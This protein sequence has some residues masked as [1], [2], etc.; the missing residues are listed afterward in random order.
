M[1]D[2]DEDS[3]I[4]MYCR[5]RAGTIGAGKGPNAAIVAADSTLIVVNIQ[6]LTY[7]PSPVTVPVGAAVVCVNHEIVAHDGVNP[8]KT[9]ESKLLEK[10]EQFPFTFSKPGTY[11]YICSIQPKMTGDVVVK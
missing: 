7:N 6:R 1:E 3:R 2:D 8:D 5:L 11:H 4:L 9:F 10:N